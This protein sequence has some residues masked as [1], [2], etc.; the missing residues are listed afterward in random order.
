[1]SAEEFLKLIEHGPRYAI[2]DGTEVKPVKTVAEWA[3]WLEGCHKDKFLRQTFVGNYRVSTV[4]L[5]LN[6]AFNPNDPPLWFETMVF[7]A[8]ESQ[9]HDFYCE[10]YGE[11][12]EALTGHARIVAKVE[13]GLIPEVTHE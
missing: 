3:T 9:F 10:R 8:D 4:F 6:H 12:E 5:G 11:Y 7:P 13:A 2:L 1:M